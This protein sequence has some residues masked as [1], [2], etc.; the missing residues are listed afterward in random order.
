MYTT[1]LDAFVKLKLEFNKQFK[2]DMARLREMSHKVETAKYFLLPV[3]NQNEFYH[4]NGSL[5][6]I[7]MPFIAGELPL[8][9]F[10]SD[11]YG[12]KMNLKGEYHLQTGRG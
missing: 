5:F 6:K 1:V 10:A 2:Q 3:V 11:I 8:V 12:G 4:T 9:V 7:I